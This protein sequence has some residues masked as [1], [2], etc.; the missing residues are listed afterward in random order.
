MAT[1]LVLLTIGIPWLGAIIV[2]LV[3]DRHAR[4]QHGL[5]SAFAVIGAIVSLGLLTIASPQAIV[6]LH[7]GGAFGDF[8]VIADGLGVYLAVIAAVIG[9]LAVI[10]SKDYMQGEEQ[11]G[12]YYALTFF[13]IGAMI[14][15][16]LTGTTSFLTIR[17]Y[18]RV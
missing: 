11:L 15:L 13:F 9:G 5:A 12:R 16:V 1:G 18:F 3:G 7:L 2:G 14:G 17:R 6:S 4:F 10:F 8:T